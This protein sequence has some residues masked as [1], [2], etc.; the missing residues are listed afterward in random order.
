MNLFMNPVFGED[1][2]GR[3]RQWVWIGYDVLPAINLDT[4]FICLHWILLLLT[5][6]DRDAGMELVEY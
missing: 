2:T 5:L 4:L 6:I 3:H 1:M